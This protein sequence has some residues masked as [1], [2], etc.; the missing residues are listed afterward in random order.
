[1]GQKANEG[2][3]Q[4]PIR[5]DKWMAVA[6]QEIADKKK[7]TF[8][9]VVHELL[10]QELAFMG[11]SMGIGREAELNTGKEKTQRQTTKKAG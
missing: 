8:T 4:K 11:Y 2:K 7:L 9:T 5:F 10:R 6:I 3:I 1:M